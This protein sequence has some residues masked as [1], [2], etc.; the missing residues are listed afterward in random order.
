[1]TQVKGGRKGSYRFIVG[2]PQEIDSL[3]DLSLDGWS[4]KWIL[5]MGWEGV[6]CIDLAQ[7]RNGLM[8]LRTG[9][10]KMT[11]SST[12]DNEPSGSVVMRGISRLPKRL[13]SF[14]GLCSM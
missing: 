12:R 13:F 8:W 6:E 5:K 1:M 9:E 10:I 11:V 7:D 14:Q 4:S 3:V 2:E